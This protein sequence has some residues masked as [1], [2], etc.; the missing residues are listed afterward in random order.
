MLRL[1]ASITEIDSNTSP[2]RWNVM[3]SLRH[4]PQVVRNSPKPDDAALLRGS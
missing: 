2:F 1:C 4:G 3:P